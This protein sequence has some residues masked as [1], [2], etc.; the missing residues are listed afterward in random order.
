MAIE[1]SIFTLQISILQLE[2]QICPEV[3]GRLCTNQVVAFGAGCPVTPN[4]HFH[5]LKNA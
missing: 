3:H 2:V 1:Q 5:V 4:G